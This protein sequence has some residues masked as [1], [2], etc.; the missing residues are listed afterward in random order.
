MKKYSLLKNTTISKISVIK[1]TLTALKKL[2]KWSERY[3]VV[4]ILR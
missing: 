4:I 3:N 2:P 1:C